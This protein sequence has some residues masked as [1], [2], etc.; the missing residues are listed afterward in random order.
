[1]PTSAG[2]LNCGLWFVS[3][4]APTRLDAL[5]GVEHA[6]DEHIA[7]RQAAGEDV[8]PPLTERRYSGNFVVRMSAA[9]HARL[10]IEAA[11]Q[12]VSI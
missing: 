1:M 3:Y 10:A 2:A 4:W 11:E 6:V 7:E 5:A 8:P 9:L 12:N